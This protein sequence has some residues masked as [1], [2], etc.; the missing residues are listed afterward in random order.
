MRYKAIIFD[1]DGTIIQT[2]HI[3]RQARHAVIT[4]R[5]ITLTP[6][7]ERDLAERCAGRATRDCCLILKEAANLPDDVEVL[8]AEK[9]ATANALYAQEIRFIEGFLDFHQHAATHKLK[10]GVATNANPQTVQATHKALD[11]ERLFG[12]HIYNISHVNYVGKPDP[13]IYL[14]AAQ[15]LA[16]EPQEC[17]AIEDSASGI[18]SAKGAGMFCI[19]INTSK[20]ADL[21]GNAHMIVNKYNEINLPSLLALE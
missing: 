10:M 15:Q 19:G 21:L 20:R 9:N 18:A 5:G 12:Q 8:I 7:L 13:G 11:L 6:E 14:H 2:E 17:I 16:I 3:W 4:S 1:M